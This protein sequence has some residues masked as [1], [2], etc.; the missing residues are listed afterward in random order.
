MERGTFD[1][2]VGVEPGQHLIKGLGLSR[3]DRSVI[4]LAHDCEA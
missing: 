4:V 1:G 2:L 3:L